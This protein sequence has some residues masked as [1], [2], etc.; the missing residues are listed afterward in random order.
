M[1]TAEIIVSVLGLAIFAGIMVVCITGYALKKRTVSK[2][3]KIKKDVD[4]S[5]ASDA[6]SLKLKK[7]VKVYGEG[8]KGMGRG[9]WR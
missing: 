6:I 8:E 7:I 3:K 1:S 2:K 5:D 4:Y 9:A